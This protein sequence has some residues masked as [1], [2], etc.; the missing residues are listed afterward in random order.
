VKLL[1]Q[2]ESF[3]MCND[4]AKVHVRRMIG[5]VAWCLLSM[6][7]RI[8]TYVK[9]GKSQARFAQLISN[10]CNSEVRMMCCTHTATNSIVRYHQSTT[11]A[12]THLY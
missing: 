12:A 9:I 3:K 7:A 2:T 5:A 6:S 4:A 1:G 10:D 11:R 8:H